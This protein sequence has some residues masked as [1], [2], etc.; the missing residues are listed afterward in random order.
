[1]PRK[2]SPPRLWLEKR[3]GREAIW[4]ILDSGR[5]ISTGC[6]EGANHEAEKRLAEYIL[7]QAKPSG[8]RRASRLAISEV[9]L[10]YLREKAPDHANPGYTAACLDKMSDFFQDKTISAVTGQG[11]RDYKRWRAEQGA[12]DSTVRRELVYL[13]AALNFY[14]REYTLDVVPQVTLP[15]EG[16]AREEWLTRSQVAVLLW[17]AWRRPKSKHLVR[18]ILIAVYTGTRPQAIFDLRWS[19]SPTNGYI[20]LE[21][22]ILYRRGTRQG[23]KKNKK[24]PPIRLPN[25]LAAHMRRWRKKDAEIGATHVVNF[26]GAPVKSVKRSWSIVREQSQISK[27]HRFYCLKH[28]AATWMMHRGVP[29]W[30]AAGFLGISVEMFEKRYGKHHPDFQQNAAGNKARSAND[31]RM[32]RAAKA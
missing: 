27:D 22:G 10:F 24:R 28:T 16:P 20:D 12:G 17:N 8:E 9:L 30:E 18:Y 2:K 4:C 15:D 5:K 3:A 32:K 6:P 31:W 21:N 14:H 7:E 23:E 19:P 13:Q 1:M 29:I 26:R 11:C 25:R